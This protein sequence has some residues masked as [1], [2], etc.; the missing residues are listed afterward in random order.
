MLKKGVS[1][2]LTPSDNRQFSNK[3]QNGFRPD[4]ALD[5]AAGASN[6]SAGMATRRCARSAGRY[7]V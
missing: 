4:D 3:E 6:R 5:G 7:I 2:H 1:Y